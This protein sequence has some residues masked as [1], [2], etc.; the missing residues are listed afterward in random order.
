MPSKGRFMTLHPPSPVP[1][2]HGLS[3]SLEMLRV[4]LEYLEI[5]SQTGQL[6][7]NSG[8]AFRTYWPAGS[9]VEG[10]RGFWNP[11]L[12]GISAI[13]T[14]TA[15]CEAHGWKV[16]WYR[17]V[18]SQV[19]WQFVCQSLER[20][21]P[22]LSYGFLGEPEDTLIVGYDRSSAERSLSVLTRHGPE[23]LLFPI[24][25]EAWPGTDARGI[26]VGLLDRIPPN[27][28]LAPTDATHRSLRRAVWQAR[29]STVRLRHLYH[30]GSAAYASWIDA[31]LA[32]GQPRGAVLAAR[33]LLGAYSLASRT[34]DGQLARVGVRHVLHRSLVSLAEARGWAAEFLREQALEFDTGP[35]ADC[36]EREARA[37][38]AAAEFWPPVVEGTP[39][40][41]RLAPE[42]EGFEERIRREETARCLRVAEEEMARA[43]REIEERVP[44]V[45]QEMAEDGED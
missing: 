43:A 29:A 20:G 39:G 9:A 40:R 15:A 21:R 22:V 17:G 34:E 7:G 27:R 16:L 14:M 5:R 2:R 33:R 24:S 1:F 31:L 4:A 30:S 42:P 41:F 19:A 45:T 18:S 32:D 28:R 26:C 25:G 3:N 35:A 13:D 10:S 36:Y 23:P 38:L 11:D 8:A 44:P 12:P 6:A 37:L